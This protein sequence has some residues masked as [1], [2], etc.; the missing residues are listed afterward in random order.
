MIEVLDKPKIRQ[1]TRRLTVTDIFD[2]V[3]PT[4]ILSKLI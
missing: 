3:P 1:C 4:E 2:C